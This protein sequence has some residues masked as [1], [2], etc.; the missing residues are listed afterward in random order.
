MSRRFRVGPRARLRSGESTDLLVVGLGNPGTEYAGT[1]H[2]VG[3]AAVAELCDRYGA[4]LKRS[5][6]QALVAEVRIDG[7]RVTLAFPQTY[8]N[9]SGQSVRRLWRQHRIEDPTQLVVVHDELD[10][11]IGTVRVKEGGG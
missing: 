5:R 4:H 7:H 6:E 10:L 9:E 8:M 11:P 2:N 3:A 1:R